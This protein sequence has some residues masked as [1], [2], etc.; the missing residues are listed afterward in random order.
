MLCLLAL[1][2]LPQQ[3]P[4]FE[5]EAIRSREE[6]G[7]VIYEVDAPRLVSA[8]L[9]LSARRAVLRLDAERYR[10]AIEQGALAP[11]VDTAPSAAR[12]TIP[13]LW[14]RRLLAGLGLP[15]DDTLLISILLEGEVHVATEDMEIL[16]SKLQDEPV[17]GRLRIENAWIRFAPLTVGPNGWPAVL[18]AELLVEEPDGTL[19]AEEAFLT[20]CTDEVPHY[21][22]SLGS[23]RV[24]RDKDGTLF[25][26]P[27]R[28]WLQILGANVIPLPTPD[29][30]PGESFFGLSGARIE[31]SRRFGT[32]IEL[33][34]RGDADWGG[35][36]VDWNFYPMLSSRRGLP[37][38]AI[39][40]LNGPGYRGRWDVFALQDSAEDVTGLRRT[41][42]RDSDTRWRTR[43][44][45]VWQLDDSWRAFAILDI[46]S[47]PLVDP[48]FFASEWMEGED[49]GSEV[50]LT[51]TGEDSF[52]YF[53]AT[54]RLDEQGATPLQGFAR[55][56]GPAAQTLEAL[57]ALDWE[58]FPQHA[59]ELPLTLAYGA[60]L[61][62]MQLR[63]RDLVAPGSVDFLGQPTSVRTRALG[64]AELAWPM[65]GG[66]AFAR[67]GARLRGSVWEDDTPGLE[68]DGQLTLEAFFETG[69]ALEKRWSDG[70]MHR[71]IPQLRLRAREEAV[72]ANAVPPIFDGLDYL[73]EGQVAEL[74]LRQFFLAPGATEPWLDLDVLAP[75]YSDATEAIA[76]L[77]GPTPW[78]TPADDG[79]G[80]VEV[81]AAWSPGIRGG[82]LEGV[83][84]DGRMRRDLSA[85][86]TETLFSRLTVRPNE[87][88]LYGLSYFETE[89]TPEDFA[90]ATLFAGWRFTEQWALGVR[91]SESF[92][93]NAGVNTG[94]A[95]QY[96][97]HDFLLEVGYTRQQVNGDVGIYFNLTPRF[98][99]DSYGSQ[100]LA[101]LR[102]Q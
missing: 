73:H 33:N 27:E 69:V 72:E 37:L 51:R 66:G 1:T 94:Y 14:S 5:A 71:V 57:P 18:R 42:G 41:V 36:A 38:R 25:W 15:E 26:Q 80:P 59:P 21:G 10:Q 40:D 49:I 44:E 93:G 23:L 63:D 3:E 48:E 81:R 96:Y 86:R 83:R 102:F 67:P 54:P 87:R 75:F 101:R 13:P 4:V 2:L 53:R 24:S 47:D 6:L 7:V 74:S 77:E 29:F 85:H 99:F 56:P 62:R 19:F 45:N 22:V 92:S 91:Q 90:F 60:S 55:A 17:A 20:T 52:A 32:A 30:I 12:E 82:A 100:R 65:H 58:A 11:A 9:Q 97:G 84:L 43:M 16:C 31:N 70:W 98:F 8:K 46:T 95:L 39:L 78:I 68:Q 76:P 34:F 50:A 89:G 64:W 61:A 79:F 28:G 35:T 88:L